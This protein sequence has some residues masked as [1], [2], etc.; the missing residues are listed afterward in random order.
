MFLMSEVPLYSDK[1]Y[2]SV[3]CFPLPGEEG[4]TP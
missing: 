4:T 3:R 2:N 1:I